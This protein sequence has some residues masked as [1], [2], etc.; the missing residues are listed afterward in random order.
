[1]IDLFSAEVLNAGNGENGLYTPPC[2]FLEECGSQMDANSAV[3]RGLDRGLTRDESLL[4]FNSDQTVNFQERLKAGQ[5]GIK[6][7]RGTDID[8][9]DDLEYRDLW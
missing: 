6:N 9:S 5:V 4:K 8:F 2:C 7:N 1:M 3:N